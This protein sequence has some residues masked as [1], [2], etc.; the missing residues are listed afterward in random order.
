MSFTDIMHLLKP[1][2]EHGNYVFFWVMV[3]FLVINL[4]QLFKK[5]SIASEIQQ[6]LDKSKDSSSIDEVYKDSCLDDFYS[7]KRLT[8]TSSSDFDYSC[9]IRSF[10]KSIDLFP[11]LYISVGILGTFVGIVLGLKG[12]GNQLGD[13][14]QLSTS[15]PILL[16]SIYLAFRTSIWGIFLGNIVSFLSNTGDMKIESLLSQVDTRLSIQFSDELQ[17]SNQMDQ[18]LGIVKEMKEERS[19]LSKELSTTIS[20]VSTNFSENLGQFSTFLQKEVQSIIQNIETDKSD[21]I[22]AELEKFTASFSNQFFNGLDDSRKQFGSQLDD[23]VQSLQSSQDSMIK[24]ITN[25]EKS[26]SLVNEQLESQLRQAK[27]MQSHEDSFKTIT[28]GLNQVLNN[29]GEFQLNYKDIL[30]GFSRSKDMER[31]NIS[32]NQK[33]LDTIVVENQKIVDKYDRSNSSMSE[34]GN[35]LSGIQC[36]FSLYTEKLDES[37]QLMTQLVDKENYL[38]EDLAG[39]Q[40]SLRD[41]FIEMGTL[42]E[43]LNFVS[44]SL[45]EGLKHS[46]EVNAQ[47]SS[48]LI[49]SI[50]IAE[51][52]R[53]WLNSAEHLTLRMTNLSDEF[54]K[55]Y[56]ENKVLVSDT[57]NNFKA[58]GQDCNQ[59]L[60][61]FPQKMESSYL[62]FDR[63]MA[64][65]CRHLNQTVTLFKSAVQE[66]ED[67]FNSLSRK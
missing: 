56:Q 3:L 33:Y 5:Y 36:S 57:S 40:N 52:S 38:V 47:V 29:F 8:G 67:S 61:K 59:L 63:N 50:T 35:L 41:K 7:S 6:I 13:V 11:N 32:L 16:D 43:N 17:K 51:N 65:I 34:L 46:K 1:S 18:M 12:L 64:E 19:K 48:S 39:F 66:A 22:L 14:E 10:P 21:K 23:N 60:N 37:V 31:E 45:V 53:S 62:E 20:S 44:T 24:I 55:L 49:N 25:L 30:E 54:T 4:F 42:S 27:E 58:L 2:M 9:S 15:I 28:Q 26:G